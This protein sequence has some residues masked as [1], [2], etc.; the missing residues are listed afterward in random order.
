MPPEK[1][2]I[3]L[4]LIRGWVVEAGKI[5]L[6]QTADRS[7]DIKADLTPVTE[8]DRQVE[9]FLL[10]QIDRHYPGHG[11]LAEEGSSRPGSD[12]TWIID[13]IDG[14][15]AFATGLPIWGIA[16]GVF[17][18]GEPY[19][20]VFYM[21]VTGDIFWG[22]REQAFHNDR[23]LVPQATVDLR[24]PLAYI[25]VPSSFHRYFDTSFRRI[26]SLG[27]AAAQ[28]AYVPFG[29][30]TAAV[31][32]RIKI[33]DMAAVL[34]YL[35]IARTRMVYLNGDPFHAADLLN[36]EAAPRP[37]VAAHE[38]I[39]DEILNTIKTK[40]GAEDHTD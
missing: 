14:T 28:L 36:G 4:D 9:G 19:A 12:F 6:S 26:R 13:P 24:S 22:T 32:R 11:V 2:D 8:I 17:H 27:S 35:G 25:A 15:R 31:T 39:L 18:L 16:V 23:P 21:P 1:P 7:V 40:P 29:M 34:P 3:N 30:A 37:L 38:S 10:E 20:G 5:A 33:W